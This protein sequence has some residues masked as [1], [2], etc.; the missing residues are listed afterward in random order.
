MQVYFGVIVLLIIVVIFCHCKKSHDELIGPPLIH[1]KA[2]EL[3][4]T[5]VTPTLDIS[6][7]HKKNVIFTADF[8]M[9][10]N[11]LI[12]LNS[13]PVSMDEMTT[14][15]ACLNNPLIK[16]G[17]LD[18]ESVYAVAGIAG[19]ETVKMISDEMK[20]QFKDNPSPEL[21]NEIV[22]GQLFAYSYLFANLSFH[23][24]F[25][26]LEIPLT[27]KG[28]Q[29]KCFGIDHYKPGKRKLRKAAEQVRIYD[30]NAYGSDDWS[31][32]EKEFLVE[33]DTIK[34]DHQLIIARINPRKTLINTIDFAFKIMREKELVKLY[35]GDNLIIPV[36][37]FK[38]EKDYPELCG[39]SIISGNPD[40]KGSSFVF[41][42]QIT[43]F[44]LD[45]KGAYVKSESALVSSIPF[46]V[47]FDESFL[48]M[49]KF[50]KSNYPYFAMW[51]ANPELMVPFNSDEIRR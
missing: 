45:E 21:L 27:F 17:D 29:V 2:G 41:A 43:Q 19:D 37:N 18:Q 40:L 15:V 23:H 3:N 32:Q 33:I 6:I 9:A 25:E 7:D 1:K 26:S 11:E 10:W 13:G 50:K 34:K 46:N 42:K 22:L 12:D 5:I 28:K 31:K 48:I 44:R 16:K 24:P 36:F 20:R 47:V 39:K 51:V 14:L 30:Y 49:M 38:L 4:E 35:E 8:Q